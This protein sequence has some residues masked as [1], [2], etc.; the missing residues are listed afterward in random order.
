MAW[1]KKKMLWNKYFFRKLSV[2]DNA[3]FVSISKENWKKSPVSLYFYDPIKFIEQTSFT[4]KKPQ[5]ILLWFLF[6]ELNLGHE[7]VVQTHTHTLE[8]AWWK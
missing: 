8:I 3:S 2:Y 1:L 6:F 7:I 4:Y 5:N